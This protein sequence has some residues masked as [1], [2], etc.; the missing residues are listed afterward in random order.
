MKVYGELSLCGT[1]VEHELGWI[2]LPWVNWRCL[3][4]SHAVW[5]KLA[6][7][8]V[9]DADEALAS[10]HNAGHLSAVRARVAEGSSRAVESDSV[11][12]IVAQLCPKQAGQGLQLVDNNGG[13]GR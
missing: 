13:Q 10:E 12:G 3:R 5:L 4:T 9:K 1:V 8:D 7:A 6:G 11:M 2:G